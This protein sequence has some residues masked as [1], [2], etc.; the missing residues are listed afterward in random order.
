VPVLLWIPFLALLAFLAGREFLVLGE[1]RRLGTAT[2]TD[3]RRLR[4]RC[5]GLFVLLLL[6]LQNE[7]VDHL[8]FADPRHEILYWGMCFATLIWLLIIAARD[9]HEIAQSWSNEQQQ[10]TLQALVEIDER[11]KRRREP[12]S[13]DDQPIRPGAQS[14]GDD[15]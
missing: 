10:V 5:L 2:P 4:R 12:G 9:A 11:L 3:F 14:P 13:A 15:L 8:E 6:A 1:A 7:L